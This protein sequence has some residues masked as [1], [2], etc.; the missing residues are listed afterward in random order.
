MPDRKRLR[1]EYLRKK[2]K[3]Y[4]MLVAWLIGLV[5]IVVM[6]YFSYLGMHHRSGWFAVLGILFYARIIWKGWRAV[7][8]SH[9]EMRLAYIPPVT[10]D[11]LPVEEILV[12]GSEEPP[13]VTS[14][15]LLRAA[16]GQETA[17]E[18]LLRITD[19]EE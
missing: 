12:R 16:N 8:R 4:A 2:G 7:D 10:P 6:M 13:V 19:H 11:T 17:K 18:E 5:A 9:K 14:A 1:Q 15:I 3:A